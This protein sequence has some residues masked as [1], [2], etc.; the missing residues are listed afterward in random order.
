MPRLQ[1]TDLTIRAL[2]SDAGQTDYWDAKTPGFGVRVGKLTKT[3]IVK[4]GSSRKA[5]GQYPS[6]SLHDARKLALGIKS[7]KKDDREKSPRFKDALET[8]LTTYCEVRNRPRVVK[9]RQVIP[10][11]LAATVLNPGR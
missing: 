9:E 2:K 11:S 6:V 3:F 8:F 1:F 5:L 7:E 10:Y 4:D